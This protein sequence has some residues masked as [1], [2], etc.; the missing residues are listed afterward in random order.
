[1]SVGELFKRMALGYLLFILCVAWSNYADAQVVM[2]VPF[3][4]I[5]IAEAPDYSSSGTVEQ[6]FVYRGI[7][8][9]GDP[10]YTLESIEMANGDYGVVIENGVVKMSDEERVKVGV[11]D[12]GGGGYSF[13]FATGGKSAALGECELSGDYFPLVQSQYQDVDLGHCLSMLEAAMAEFGEVESGDV[14]GW[15]NGLDYSYEM[16]TGD[17][18]DS[19]LFA[20]WSADGS[21]NPDVED[22]TA[23]LESNVVDTTIDGANDAQFDELLR[24]FQDLLDALGEAVG[25]CEIADETQLPECEDLAQ[26]LTEDYEITGNIDSVNGTRTPPPTCYGPCGGGGSEEPG[27]GDNADVVAAL[28]RLRSDVNN[29]IDINNMPDLEIDFG[30]LDA[31]DADDAIGDARATEEGFV[32]CIEEGGSGC[33]IDADTFDGIGDVVTGFLPSG[34]TCAQAVFPVLPAK[35]IELTIDT[36][37][38]E[39]I[40]LIVEWALGAATVFALYA[41]ATGAKGEVA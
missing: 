30:E 4:P 23:E 12:L 31:S 33:T 35:G 40:R 8:E 25:E 11:A 29:G 20:F 15:C 39:T 32:E 14:I 16:W 9:S 21:C 36:C 34:G 22:L 28:E 26:Q 2:D 5:G 18:G 19:D 3:V 41:M 37:K 7:D 6:I 27:D 24:R 1:M 17:A 38:L 13:I 10:I